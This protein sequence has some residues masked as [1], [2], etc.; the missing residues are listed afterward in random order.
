VASIS[1]AV[2]TAAQTLPGDSA[3][4]DAELLLAHALRQS[5]AWLYAHGDDALAGAEQ[6]SFEDL[7]RRRRRGEPIAQIVG[8][9]GFWT[10]DLE[11]NA[12]TLIPRPETELLVELA[13]A[14]IAPDR[15]VSV[16]DLG[17]G[18]GAIA[19]AIASERPLAA[20]TAVDSSEPALR[21]ARRNAERLGL[22]RVRLLASAWFSALAAETFELIVSNPPYI[23]VD[24]P[25]LQQGDLRFEPRTALASGRDGL[26]DIRHI[27][28]QAPKHLATSG[29]LLIEH[30]FGQGADVRQLLV[31]AGFAQVETGSDLEGRERV[32]L[33]RL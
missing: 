28:M 24:D 12:D 3:R 4:L 9:R 5:R 10:F 29:W 16:L 25:H 1:Q 26:D 13:L 8:R 11:V 22:T 14:R 6:Q 15:S 31:A 32:T 21:I 2:Q 33:G 27:V 17:T 19:L 7:L 20:V 30:G 18:T 23:A